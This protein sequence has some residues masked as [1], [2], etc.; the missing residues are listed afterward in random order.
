MWFFNQARDYY[1][2]SPVAQ[3]LAW[4]VG[5]ALLFLVVAFIGFHLFR[6]A[7]GTPR[8]EV[9][10]TP[11]PAGATTIR[12]YAIG[13]LLYHWGI[14]GVMVLL[15][16]SGAAVFAWVFIAFVLVHIGIAIFDTGLHNML[17]HRGD[18]HDLMRRVGYYLGGHGRLPKHGKFDVLQKTYHLLLILFAL[19]MIVTGISL[20]LNSEM[21]ATLDANW[22]RWQRL[23]HDIFAF[24]FLAVIVAHVYLRLLGQRRAKL[25]SIFTGNLSR[26]EFEREHD[27]RRWQPE[28]SGNRSS[29]AAARVASD[30]EK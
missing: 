5:V 8:Y 9:K 28:R 2:A 26:A 21:F 25:A 13:G 24:L 1:T 3:K 18:G 12:R 16:V 4:E 19:V 7:F 10:G 11:P 22:L 30:S 17:F 6:R 23:L 27:W 15:L 29:A 14:F 20:F